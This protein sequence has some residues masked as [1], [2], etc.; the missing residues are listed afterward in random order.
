ME[1][2]TRI[3]ATEL[4]KSLSDVLNRVRYRGE[5]FLI[6]RNGEPVAALVAVAPVSG[7]ITMRELVALLKDLPSP[8][9]RFADDLEAIHSSQHEVLV[10]VRELDL[11]SQLRLMEEV[12]A[13]V[14]HRV[15]AQPR[16]SILEL[17]G[18]GK[19]IWEGIDAQEYVERERASWGG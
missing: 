8:D 10:Q 2:E 17:Q 6:V 13:L 15:A 5:K 16:H 3:T 1:M 4:A 18:L 14:R 9:D 7:D 11:A 19:E 12:A